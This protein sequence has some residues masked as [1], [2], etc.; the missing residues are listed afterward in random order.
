MT[1][2]YKGM[3]F[4]AE[5]YNKPFAEFKKEFGSTHVFNNIHPDEREQ[6]LEAAYQIATSN[7]DIPRTT[8]KSKEVKS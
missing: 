3:I 6:E 2:N 1:A 5:G 4:F 7:G 8:S